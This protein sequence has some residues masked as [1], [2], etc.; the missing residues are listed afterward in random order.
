MSI[1]TKDELAKQVAERTGLEVGQ[2]KSAVDATI[3]EITSQLAAGNE[4]KFTGFGKFSA[5]ARP[6]REGRNPQTGESMTIAAKTA[7]KFSPGAEL[8]KAVNG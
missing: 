5:V 8:K 6:A 4:V 7:P 1:T 2:A 3:A